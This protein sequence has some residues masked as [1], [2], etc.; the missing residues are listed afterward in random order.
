MYIKEIVMYKIYLCNTSRMTEQI[1]MKFLYN[2]SDLSSNISTQ[3]HQNLT[4]INRDIN[5]KSRIDIQT[6]T[7]QRSYSLLDLDDNMYVDL[8]LIQIRI[9]IQICIHIIDH[10]H[11]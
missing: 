7:V 5:C 9:N 2:Q 10:N 11:V 3:F 8:V 1:F 6:D 4:H